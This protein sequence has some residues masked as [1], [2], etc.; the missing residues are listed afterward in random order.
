MKNITFINI[1]VSV[2]LLL[3]VNS[4]AVNPVTGKRDLMLISEDREIAMGAES[5]P[6]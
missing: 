3:F 6:E 4:C 2:V 5:D 1:T